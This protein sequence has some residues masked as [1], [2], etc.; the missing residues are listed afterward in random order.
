M[1]LK[2]IH[3]VQYK[4]KSRVYKE[5]NKRNVLGGESKVQVLSPE[6]SKILK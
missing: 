2:Q 4:H 3:K 6:M 1:S 5:S